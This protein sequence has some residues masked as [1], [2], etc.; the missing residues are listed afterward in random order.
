MSKESREKFRWEVYLRDGGRCVLCGEPAQDAHHILER[1]LWKDGGYHVDNG[2]SVCG[3]CHILCERTDVDLETIRQACGILKPLLPE[4]FYDD[5]KYDKWGNILLEDG[6]RLQG[7]LFHDES[8]QKI[9]ADKLHLFTSWVKYPRTCHVPWSEGMHDDDRMIPTMDPFVG[10]RVIVSR[11]MDGENTTLYTDYIHAR[12]VDGRNH[13]SR[14][15]V[16]QFW[17]QIRMDIPEGWRVC[18]ENLYAKHSIPYEALPSY[19]LGFSIWNE[20]NW[21]LSWDETMEWFELLGITSVPVLYDG[22]Y[23]EKIIR[24]LWK[25]E[26]WEQ[27]EGYVIRLAKSFPYSDFKSKV[28]KYVRLRHIQT[29]K[30]WMYGQKIEKNGLEKKWDTKPGT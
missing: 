26:D 11:K 7:E 21:C 16:K 24:G 23:D 25:P 27:H 5:Q 18:G 9:L 29:T 8:V 28:A 15:W 1:R 19:L 17:S 6:R 12:S 13:P 4:H 20:K 30:H 22:V 14:N 3:P 10:K 2:A